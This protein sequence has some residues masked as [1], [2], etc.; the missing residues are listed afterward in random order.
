MNMNKN[1]LRL[2]FS[3]LSFG[4]YNF[5]WAMDEQPAHFTVNDEPYASDAIFKY[6]EA[7]KKKSVEISFGEIGKLFFNTQQHIY[8]APV[9]GDTRS[10]NISFYKSPTSTIILTGACCFITA[11][12]TQRI[13][14]NYYTKINTNT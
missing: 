6:E 12:I 5:C 14:K 1:N 7:N 10:S 13:C 2:I 9:M 3:I 4:F 8:N 11:L